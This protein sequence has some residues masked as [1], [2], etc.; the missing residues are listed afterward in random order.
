MAQ[1]PCDTEFVLQRIAPPA[2]EVRG[3]PR[4]AG[5]GRS[6]GVGECGCA[7]GGGAYR[8]PPG[9]RAAPGAT[10]IDLGTRG[11]PARECAS[12]VNVDLGAN[13]APAEGEL[14]YTT[15]GMMVRIALTP[16]ERKQSGEARR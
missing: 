12:N 8:L 10:E 5:R 14:P 7:G 4:E 16:G 6:I 3:S 9:E 15:G 2:A 1:W 13:Q 11:L